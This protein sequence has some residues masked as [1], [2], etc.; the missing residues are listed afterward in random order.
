MEKKLNE[1]IDRLDDIPQEFATDI[2]SSDQPKTQAS[3][4]DNATRHTEV[5]AQDAF[6]S[7]SS[8]S[9]G[10]GFRQPGGSTPGNNQNSGPQ[11]INAGGLI[12]GGMVVHF[13]DMLMPIAISLLV[14]RASGKK[15]PKNWYKL[16][17]DEKITLEPV[18]QNWLN[19][20]NFNVDN[21][22]TAL[23]ITAGFIY[24]SKTIEA[25]NYQGPVP[26]GVKMP[27]PFAPGKTETRGRHKKDCQCIVCK[28]RRAKNK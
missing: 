20:V 11:Q 23:I 3:I 7:L 2:T 27:S 24:G 6:N 16:T 12:T 1:V 19:S 14:E 5:T 4:L 13:A 15:T 25:L 22:A 21:P 9:I 8:Q 10:E 26:P 18:L 17:N 28:Q